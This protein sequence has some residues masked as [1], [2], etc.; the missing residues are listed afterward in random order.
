MTP[1]EKLAF[2]LQCQKG[3]FDPGRGV[4]CSITNDKPTFEHSCNDYLV[5]AVRSQKIAYS[6]EKENKEKASIGKT[7]LVIA[8]V[9]LLLKFILF[10]IRSN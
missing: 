5:D 1:K 8:I 4:I 7:F 10:M 9:G 3:A 6:H 2:C